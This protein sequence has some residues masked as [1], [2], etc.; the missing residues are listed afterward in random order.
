MTDTKTDL[1]ALIARQRELA[2][3]LENLDREID[4]ER[5]ALGRAVAAGID[6]SEHR[7]RARALVEEA[8]G[9]RRAL[10]VLQAE[11]DAGRTREREGALDAAK[12]DEERLVADTAVAYAE[13]ER[14]LR[15][16][17]ENVFLPLVDKAELTAERAKHAELS[18][19]RLAGQ[20][21]PYHPRA[22]DVGAGKYRRVPPFAKLLRGLVAG[23]S[24]LFPASL[25]PQQTPQTGETPLAF[26]GGSDREG[27]PLALR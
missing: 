20:P 23:E 8:E 7:D 26:Q 18:R 12:E 6:G 11:I 16:F 10:P 5:T 19:C 24:Y 27:N 3:K 25:P 17:A 2:N 15:E 14:A 1:S 9:V 4:Q 22:Y 21:I 13:A